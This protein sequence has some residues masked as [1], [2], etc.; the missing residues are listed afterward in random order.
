[1]RQPSAVIDE[2]LAELDTTPERRLR[3]LLARQAAEGVAITPIGNNDDNDDDN[4][5]TNDVQ[6]AMLAGADV[7]HGATLNEEI[8]KR[9]DTGPSHR[10]AVWHH[11]AQHSRC[12]CSRSRVRHSIISDIKN[13]YTFIFGDIRVKDIKRWKLE[14]RRPDTATAG[15]AGPVADADLVAFQTQLENLN[16]RLTTLA[17]AV[18][19][20]ARVRLHRSPAF[21]SAWAA[22][23]AHVLEDMQNSL[24]VKDRRK[25]LLRSYKSC[26]LGTVARWTGRS[27]P[28]RAACA[29]G[30]SRARLA[31]PG[32]QAA[33]PSRG[34]A[35]TR[36]PAGR[37]RGGRRSTWRASSWKWAACSK[38]LKR[39]T[40]SRTTRPCT[41]SG[42]WRP[43]R[44]HRSARPSS[45]SDRASYK[46]L[47]TIWR[48]PAAAA[49][50]SKPCSA[51]KTCLL[52]PG[53]TQPVHPQCRSVVATIVGRIVLA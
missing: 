43:R 28:G 50:D 48:L 30:R 23:I 47:C 52:Y 5:S 18:V 22:Q 29:H 6:Y 1:M 34:S 17:P 9:F 8:A 3:R 2:I 33:T 46:T 35:R 36:W 4:M 41:A 7:F 42:R 13:K 14:P 39:R 44:R 20:A 45:K 11:G 40:A 27:T 15:L 37:S 51:A 31:C 10:T 26:F 16:V 25:G 19:H 12:P 38:S 32:A 21:P 49:A 24:Q 53:S